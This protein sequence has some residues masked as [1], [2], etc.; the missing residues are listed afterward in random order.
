LQAERI[1]P[2]GVLLFGASFRCRV[3]DFVAIGVIGPHD[4]DFLRF[5]ETAHDALALIEA[6]A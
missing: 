1:E 3:I 6:A 4:L 2:L 5:S